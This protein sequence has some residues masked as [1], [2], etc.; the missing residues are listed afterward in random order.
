MSETPTSEQ[1][2]LGNVMFTSP[3]TDSHK[4]ILRGTVEKFVDA[5]MS[6]DWIEANILPS[7]LTVE[8]LN[9]PQ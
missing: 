5:G 9:P 6:V 3:L 1:E 2:W 4:E 8:E 7:N